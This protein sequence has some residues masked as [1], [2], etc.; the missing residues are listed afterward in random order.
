MSNSFT[1]WQGHDL[2]IYFKKRL[3]D[4]LFYAAGYLLRQDVSQWNGEVDDSAEWK[5]LFQHASLANDSFSQ[6]LTRFQ[7][8]SLHLYLTRKCDLNCNYCFSHPA[9]SNPGLMNPTLQAMEKAAALVIENCREDDVPM[10]L[11]CHGGGEPTL[12]PDLGSILE[13]VRQLCADSQVGLFSYLATNGVMS[14]AKAEWIC[15]HFDLVGLSCDGPPSIQD[16]QRPAVSGGKTSGAVERTAAILRQHK[17]A[18]Q[19]RVTLTGAAWRQMPEIA[20]YMVKQIQPQGV[21]VELA[22]RTSDPQLREEELRDFIDLYFIAREMCSKAGIFWR[23]SGV[24]PGQSHRQYCHI[25]QNTLEVL[26]GDT[27]SLC[28]LDNDSNESGHRKTEIARFDP[29]SQRW[30][31]DMARVSAIQALLMAEAGPCRDCFA[32]AH[33]SRSCPDQCPL[34]GNL[35]FPDLRCHLNQRML[36]AQLE[37]CAEQLEERCRSQQLSIAGMEIVEC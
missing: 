27:A 18:F 37:R 13:Y 21:N 23:N 6:K 35:T 14:A 32:S 26:P 1:R 10:T 30:K 34:E 5:E 15:G 8:I 29:T 36:D 16:R 2:P 20:D 4:I 31:M 22:Y 11:V 25:L 33:C 9:S 17:Q 3:N 7:P 24:R 12:Y 28:F 19:V